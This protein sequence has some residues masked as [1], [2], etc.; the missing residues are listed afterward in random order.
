[1]RTGQVV[2]FTASVTLCALYYVTWRFWRW[3]EAPGLLF[4]VFSQPWTWLWLDALQAPVNHLLGW[5]VR[6]VLD[7]SIISVGFSLN[8]T[9]V[10]IAAACGVKRRRLC[11]GGHTRN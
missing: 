9:L 7:A 6:A 5:R 10:F 2:V 11:A 1:M 8:T 3:S 4:L